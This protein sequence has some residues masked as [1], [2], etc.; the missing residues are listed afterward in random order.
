MKKNRKIKT[1]VIGVGSFGERHAKTYSEIPDVQLVAVVDADIQRAR[2]IAK[3]YACDAFSDIAALLGRIDAA[4]IVTPT[5]YHAGVA[6]ALL[7]E[8][9]DVLIEKPMTATLEEADT[10]NQLA[11]EKKRIVQVGHI[12]RFNPVIMRLNEYAIR[13][14][15][16]ECHR[17]SPFMERAANVSVVLD[18]MIHDLDIVLSLA[19]ARPIEVH[20]VG[21]SVVSPEIDIA[22]AR[23]IFADGLVANVMASR[24]SEERVRTLRI[25]QDQGYFSVDYLQREITVYSRM[26]P[27]GNKQQAI[28]NG[29]YTFER[30]D[31]LK[32][33]LGQFIES[34]KTR[35]TPIV[36]G[37][38]GKAALAVALQIIDRIKTNH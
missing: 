12:E 28:T 22:H 26:N 21:L 35:S 14:R 15:L 10:I 25:F 38:T 5:R 32:T 7:K 19:K 16:I 9:V 3:L 36:S 34:V 30:V 11:H 20:A 37:E 29:K 31:A 27:N 1:A 8:G 23:L 33:E 4:S 2:E 6:Q 17:M 18:L 13:P 24:A